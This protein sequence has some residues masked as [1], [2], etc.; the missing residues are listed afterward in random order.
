M[1]DLAYVLL[2]LTAFAV[3]LGLVRL[4]DG[5]APVTDPPAT[6]DG[7]GDVAAPADPATAG[8]PR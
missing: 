7:A 8:T 4:L 2:T 3:L 6:A 1:A 5:D